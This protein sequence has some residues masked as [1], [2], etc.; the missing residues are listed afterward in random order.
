MSD[1]REMKQLINDAAKSG[2]DQSFRNSVR[3]DLLEQEIENTVEISGITAEATDLDIDIDKLQSQI[4]RARVASIIIW[5]VCG[6]VF[7]ARFCMGGG[8]LN[9]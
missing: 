8:V 1:Y 5:A 3:P 7:I 6:V 4:K 9:G 2:V